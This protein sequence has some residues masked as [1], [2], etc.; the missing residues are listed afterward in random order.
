MLVEDEGLC[1]SSELVFLRGY[2]CFLHTPSPLLSLFFVQYM[3][4][5]VSGQGSRGF[6]VTRSSQSL[7]T[8]YCTPGIF[9]APSLLD[10]MHGTT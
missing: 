9:R 8:S 5:R 10:N 3:N 2:G 1:W 4:S 7:T 6:G